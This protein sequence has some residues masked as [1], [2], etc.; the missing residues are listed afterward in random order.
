MD[1]PLAGA[2][3][4]FGRI[5]IVPT[6]LAASLLA[7][8]VAVVVVQGWTLQTVG[9]S[10]EHA[11]QLRLDVN[12]ALLKHEMHQRGTDWR[13]APDG[14]LTVDGKPAEDLNKVVD[15]VARIT[16]AV[17]TVFAGDTRL[18]T[19]VLR[20]DGSPATGTKLAAGSAREA[21]IDHRSTYRGAAD[22]LGVPH[23]TVYEPLLDPDGREVGILFVGVPSADVQAVL[24]RII[25]NTSIVA[26][27]VILIVG[28]GIWL[29]LRSTLRPLQALAAAVHTISDGQLDVSVPCASR[30]DQLGEIG[31]AVELLRGKAQD[32]QRLDMQAAANT[33]AKARRQEAIDQLTQ[34]FGASASGVL[35]GLVSSAESMR[36]SAAEM[37]DAAEKT[38]SD[39]TSATADAE[40]SSQNL[41][42]VAAAAEELTASVGEIS[43]QVD[44]SA[45][46]AREAVEQAFAADAMV[47][48]LSDAADKIGQVVGLIASIAAQT[49]LLALNA[50]IE[51]ARAG[52]AG[53]GFAVVAGEVKHLAAQT[54]EATRQISL[55]VGA[56]QT[57]TGAAAHAVQAVTAA[58]GRVSQVATTIAT[59]VEQQGY[60]T[61]EIAGK[62][63]TIAKATDKATH[64]MLDVS[65]AAERSGQISQTVLVSANQVTQVSGTLRAEVDH[66]MQAM[67]TSQ[68]SEQR[69]KYERIEGAGTQVDLRRA[70]HGTASKKIIDISL[71]GAALACDWPCEAGTE[72]MLCLPGGGPEVSSRVVSVRGN[73][74]AVAFRQDPQ[75]LAHVA[76]AIDWITAKFPN[77]GRDLAA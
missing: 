71:G 56:I 40:L 14:R 9:R 42:T 53:K 43:R 46:A 4:L 49:N 6:L 76:Q 48:G 64:A 55:Q 52:E 27:I 2:R 20:P 44:Q 34:D 47:G 67:R 28:A 77:A 70:E 60:A 51:A 58:I 12:L 74:L 31:R 16:Q 50:T 54:A 30:T 24:N 41:S 33:R 15:D 65:N 3:R 59:A 10:E 25:W 73:V 57:A 32:A 18:A 69:R 11:A 26:L 19:T 5:G 7:V 62:V 38:R 75:T 17:A 8:V 61:T 45:Q 37:A 29:M 22:I 63:N 23:F 66:F 39:M 35:A 68:E 13:L 21:V 72:I 36:G 1:W